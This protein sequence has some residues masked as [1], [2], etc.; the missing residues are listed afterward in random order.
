MCTGMP[1]SSSSLATPSTVSSRWLV[2]IWRMALLL[3]RHGACGTAVGHHADQSLL[4]G[5]GHQAALAVEDLAARQS[6]RGLAAGAVQRVQEPV[7]GAERAVE[8][9]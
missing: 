2:K 5:A 7:V 9:Q 1:A 6:A 3:R 8:P 4:R